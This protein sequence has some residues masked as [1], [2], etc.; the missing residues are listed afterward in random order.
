MAWKAVELKISWTKLRKWMANVHLRPAHLDGGLWF[1]KQ[2]KWYTHLETPKATCFSQSPKN[3]LF[4]FNWGVT[5][6]DSIILACGSKLGKVLK[7]PRSSRAHL[8]RSALVKK[9]TFSA[10]VNARAVSFEVASEGVSW[11]KKQSPSLWCSWLFFSVVFAL[12]TCL[13]FFLFALSVWLA[14]FV[15]CNIVFICL[16]LSLAAFGW[17]GVAGS[18][19]LS[20]AKLDECQ[21]VIRMPRV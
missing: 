3:C 9:I 10:L 7:C 13:S 2:K 12:H 19:S 11:K 6:L 15:Y 14:V 20:L 1:H 21:K 5:P 8:L 17:H 18:F 4:C 16:F